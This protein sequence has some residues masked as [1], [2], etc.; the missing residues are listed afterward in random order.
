[1]LSYDEAVAQV[2]APGQIFELA[3]REIDGVQHHVFAHAPP[4]LRQVFAMM[5]ARPDETFLV[6]EDERW[7]FGDV[8]A[9]IDALAATL[10]QTYGI[11]P[12]D[13]VGIAMR[14]YPEW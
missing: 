10:V 5:Q 7:T 4:T 12:G 14:N 6:Y 9:A 13:R 1:M 2:T 8:T 3:Q 11:S